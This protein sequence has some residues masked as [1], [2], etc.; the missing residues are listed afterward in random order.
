MI[1]R[2]YHPTKDFPCFHTSIGV[3]ELIA[4]DGR[5]VQLSFNERTGEVSVRGWGNI[6]AS[7][8]NLNQLSFNCVLNLEKLEN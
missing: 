3:V 1:I 6:P 2:H 5:T 8:G 4:C 7:L